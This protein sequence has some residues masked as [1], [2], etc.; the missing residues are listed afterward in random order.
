MLEE[1]KSHLIKICLFKLDQCARI[2]WDFVGSSHLEALITF[3]TIQNYEKL[4]T[5][6]G[7]PIRKSRVL[8]HSMPPVLFCTP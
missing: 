7:K 2:S 1:G 8:T 6:S 5:K 4:L 3:N